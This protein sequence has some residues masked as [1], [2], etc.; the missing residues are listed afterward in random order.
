MSG[1]TVG[2]L[3]TAGQ[4]VFV[5]GADRIRG[6]RVELGPERLVAHQASN[7]RFGE[8][9]CRKVL[10]NIR[11]VDPFERADEQRLAKSSRQ[12][13]CDRP[14]VERV[15]DLTT[16]QTVDDRPNGVQPVEQCFLPASAPWPRPGVAVL[17]THQKHPLRDLEVGTGP[18]DPEAG[19]LPRRGCRLEKLSPC[20]T[21]TLGR[22]RQI[23]MHH[24]RLPP[25]EP[26]RFGHDPVGKRLE[27]AELRPHFVL[28][29]STS[30]P[31]FDPVDEFECA[32]RVL[33]IGCDPRRLPQVL[34][35]PTARE[36][37]NP[38]AGSSLLTNHRAPSRLTRTRRQTHRDP[39]SLDEA[40]LGRE[41][42]GQRDRG[43]VRLGADLPVESAYEDRF[44]GRP[45]PLLRH[46]A[47]RQRR[48]P[49]SSNVCLR[50]PRPFGHHQ[51]RSF[52]QHR[53]VLVGAA[54]RG[55]S[56]RKSD[57]NIG[58]PGE[59][60]FQPR[61]IS[62]RLAERKLS[63]RP[64]LESFERTDLRDR[65]LIPA[66]TKMGIG[67]VLQQL[68]HRSDRRMSAER[69]LE[70]SRAHDVLPSRTR[71]V[72]VRSKAGARC[73]RTTLDGVRAFRLTRAATEI[74][75]RVCRSEERP[76]RIRCWLC[77]ASAG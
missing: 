36:R 42:L 68:K 43:W 11:H 63:L 58:R 49:A 35:A 60:R 39:I 22:H 2:P 23:G 12:P 21:R 50:G 29:D 15:D 61:R 64:L 77:K 66:S 7:E 16:G 1:P 31:I 52:G 27:Q 69:M 45:A 62:G 19:V 40:T 24:E 53:V 20:F 72:E 67:R 3:T 51:P 75:S 54:D 26:L 25:R 37:P 73:T 34:V 4:P 38:G 74:E 55:Q 6:I 14:V 41:G 47:G 56:I 32:G 57:V 70:A 5:E 30:D 28:G 46:A 9:R 71:C 8:R 17:Q 13:P 48:S 18:I 59:R 65:G 10:L 44:E 76:T 33:P